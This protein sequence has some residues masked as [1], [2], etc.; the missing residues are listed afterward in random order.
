[1]NTPLVSL[2]FCISVFCISPVTK[3]GHPAEHRDGLGRVPL[4]E[5]TAVPVEIVCAARPHATVVFHYWQTE[6]GHR[7]RISHRQGIDYAPFWHGQ[8]ATRDLPRLAALSTLVEQMGAEYIIDFQGDAC[9]W[10]VEK[11][12]LRC[13][14]EERIKVG[15]APPFASLAVTLRAVSV[16]QREVALGVV[17]KDGRHP[18][19]NSLVRLPMR[20]YESQESP[21]WTACWAKAAKD[22]D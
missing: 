17:L 5:L 8:V 14:H 19:F 13:L 22:S 1:M 9:E 4:Y 18:E 2:A 20:F 3:A 10:Q 16:N 11:K 15:E 12:A 6:G 21:Q 7:V